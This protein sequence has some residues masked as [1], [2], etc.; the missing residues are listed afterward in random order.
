MLRSSHMKAYNGKAHG[1]RPHRSHWVALESC[2]HT[3]CV[4]VVL[5]IVGAAHQ[6]LVY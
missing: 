3:L 2:P 1:E 6:V 5:S 4:L